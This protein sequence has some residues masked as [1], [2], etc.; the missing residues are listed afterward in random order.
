MATLLRSAWMATLARKLWAENNFLLKSLNWDKYVREGFQDVTIPQESDDSGEVLTNVFTFPITVN[1][2][3]DD[4]IKYAM[5]NY[6]L[7]PRRISNL[8]QLQ[9]DHGFRD[10]VINSGGNLLNQ[11]FALD[12]LYAWRA[13]QAKFI[14]K[15]TGDARDA[16]LV[17]ST[18]QRKKT[19]MRDFLVADKIM[20]DALIPQSNRQALCSTQVKLD[21]LEDP[22]ILKN[23]ALVNQ[24]ANYK[25]G[26][27]LQVCNFD[28]EFRPT[29]QVFNA[30]GTAAKTPSSTI[31]AGDRQ[32]SILWH[33]D[34]VGRSMG[35]TQVMYNPMRADYFGDLFSAETNG[36]G[37]KFYADG[38]GV[39][40]LIEDVV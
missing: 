34:F 23:Q 11:T 16:A 15:T 39:I 30:A 28:L 29:V 3:T 25:T 24:L 10:S 1:E 37:S 18:G 6:K 36:G 9:Y 38:R 4:G 22:E 14:L 35:N 19:T 12:I 21:L 2:R 40:S 20:N 7:K 13:E 33:P 5:N 8:A 26:T 27:I 32:A 31:A 17:G